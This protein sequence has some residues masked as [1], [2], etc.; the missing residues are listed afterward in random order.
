MSRARRCVTASSASW[1]PLG[2][3][4]LAELLLVA[5]QV[6]LECR[7]RGIAVSARGSATSSLVAWV[8][9]LVELCPLDY[10]LDGQMF[11]HDGRPDLPDLDLEVPSVYE[12]AVA[13]FVQQAAAAPW[14]TPDGEQREQLPQVHALR[15]GINVSLGSRQAVRA[16]G[17]AFGLEAPRSTR[18]LARC[19]CYRVL[20]PSSRS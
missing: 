8:L 17:A 15:L 12:P 19:R 13:A 10:G 5:Q 7:T 1:S 16:T 14:A 11:M 4:G 2:R 20:A 9:G 18:S 6:A 3:T